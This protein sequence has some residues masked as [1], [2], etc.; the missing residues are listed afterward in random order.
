MPSTQD[1]FMWRIAVVVILSSLLTGCFASDKPMF[2]P[3]SGVRALGDGGKYAAF[4]I[5][6]GKESPTD[7]MSARRIGGN[8]YEFIDE[9]GVATHV[10]FH[11]LPN[12]EYVAQ[13]ELEDNKGYGYLVLRGGEKEVVVT[14]IECNKQD[15]AKMTELGVTRRTDYECRIDKVADPIAFFSSLKRSLPVSRLVRQ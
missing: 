13:A 11:A 3:D 14:P 15:A 8:I 5:S 6:D 9:K 1:L 4:E 2:A 12:G 10:T 7:P